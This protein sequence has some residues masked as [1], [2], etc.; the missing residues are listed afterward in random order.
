MNSSWDAIADVL[1]RARRRIRDPS[2]WTQGAMTRIDTNGLE[3]WCALQAIF[4]ET[5]E[6]SE[7]YAFVFEA[8]A[9]L[10]RSGDE[11]ARVNDREG[12]EA[13]IAWL[14]ETARECR[15]CRKP[16]EELVLRDEGGRGV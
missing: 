7:A 16:L 11:C 5:G 4:L 10:Q 13:I 1:D 14:E 2:R 3:R 15:R 6:D 9:Y 8:L 12:H